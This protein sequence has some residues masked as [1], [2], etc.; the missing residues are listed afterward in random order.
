MQG[1]LHPGPLTYF[2]A[3]LFSPSP[4]EGCKVKCALSTK[5]VLLSTAISTLTL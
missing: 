4:S 1:Y 2:Y 5:D 3:L